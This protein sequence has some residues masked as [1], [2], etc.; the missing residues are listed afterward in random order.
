MNLSLQD[1][2]CEEECKAFSSAEEDLVPFGAECT[3]DTS[4][5][6]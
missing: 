5:V 3:E 1:N 6:R 2:D 4:E